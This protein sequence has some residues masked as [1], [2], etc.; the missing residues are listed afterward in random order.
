MEK[1]KN[2][3]LWVDD[4]IELL[5]SNILFLEDK[6]Y[7]VDKAT[8]GEDAIEMAKSKDYDL[9]F[10]DEMMAG[11]GGLATGLRMRIVTL[12]ALVCL[13]LNGNPRI[14]VAQKANADT[15]SSAPLAAT[16]RK[17]TGMN[18]DEIVRKLMQEYQ[19]HFIQLQSEKK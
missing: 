14:L 2:K 1:T 9:I 17:P 15:S 12:G 16:G 19:T 13:A 18:A 3:I 7:A 11:M 4:E 6:G 5:R 8:N 10:L